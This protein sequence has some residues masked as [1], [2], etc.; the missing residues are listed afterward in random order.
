MVS[1]S[2]WLFGEHNGIVA[3]SGLQIS[4]DLFL[5]RARPRCIVALRNSDIAMAKKHGNSI[6]GNAR[7]Q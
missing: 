3:P 4:L 5:S 1:R 6:E 7:E 2:T